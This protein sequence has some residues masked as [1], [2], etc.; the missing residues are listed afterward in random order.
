MRILTI[1]EVSRL[2]QYS[3]QTVKNRLSRRLPLPPS[4]RVGKKRLWVESEVHEWIA[5]LPRDCPM[6]AAL[7]GDIR[8]AERI[9][10]AVKRR[11][12]RPRTLHGALA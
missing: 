6:E 9:E 3:E 8:P 2:L 1:T 10:T 4:F 12:G 7:T 11:R 5:S